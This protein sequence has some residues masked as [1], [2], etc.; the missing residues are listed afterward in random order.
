MKTSKLIIIVLALGALA[1]SALWIGGCAKKLEG[2]AYENEKPIVW[3]VNVPPEGAR[4]SVNPIINWY[5]QD[6]DGQINFFRYIVIRESDL[7]VTLGKPSDWNPLSEPLSET[8][9]QTFVNDHLAN[10]SDTLWT[11]LLVRADSVDPHTS[12]IIPMSAQIDNPVL[13]FVPQFVFVQAFDEKG[14]GSDIVYRRFLRNDNPPATR[15]VGFIDGVAFINAAVPTG[16]ATGVRIRW[17]GSDVIDY[18]SEAPPF[19][20]EWKLF[21]PYTQAQYDHILDFSM[22]GPFL[23]KVFVTND[24]RVFKFYEPAV[25]ITDTIWNTEHTAEDSIITYLQGTILVVCD[26]TFSGGIETEHCDTILID[27]VPGSNIYGNVDTLLQVWDE[28]FDT[29]S[30]YIVADSSH[31]EFGNNWTTELS[32]SIYDVY[33]DHPADT[34]QAGKYIFVIRSRDDAKV[35]DLTPAF[36]GFTVINPQHERDIL[37]VDWLP[38]GVENRAK[39]NSSKGYWNAAIAN[40]MSVDSVPIVYSA[41]IDYH[42]IGDYNNYPEEILIGLLKHKVAVMI[43]DG[44]GG[45]TWGAQGPMT[46][47]VYTALQSGVN[48]WVAMRVPLGNY[49]WNSPRATDIANGDYQYFFGVQQIAFP[50]WGSYL[51]GTPLGVPRVEDFVGALSLD[52]DQW[53]DLSVDTTLLRIR[54]VWEPDSS[55]TGILSG[56][57]DATL[58]PCYPYR[59]INDAFAFLGAIPQ[60]GWCVRSYDTECMYLFKSLYGNEHAIVRDLS[61]HGRPVGIRLDRGL[62]RTVHFMFTPSAL[63]ASTAYP[64]TRSVLNWLYEGRNQGLALA[65]G[66]GSSDDT[67]LAA[68]LSSRYWKAYWEANGDKD[69]FYELLKNAY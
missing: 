13:T 52:K 8:E 23:K 67:K 54:Y 49:A 66:D 9:M 24:A 38:T 68:D 35:P 51:L 29:S 42:H 10:I 31:D 47:S 39:Y 21:G 25:T 46:R 6:R 50:G 43:Q 69:K 14:L 34:T 65:K 45:G 30:Y 22:R 17:S 12:N 36:K 1:L 32:D 59:D 41:A 19:E 18:P 27:T 44:A 28:V 26:T 60:V 62:F 33:K 48:I 37:V 61:Y 64:M 55:T 15:I 3:F 16:P 58:F 20:F 56:W 63:E 11:R 4:S 40:W 57:G 5:G 2:T 53:P 7:G